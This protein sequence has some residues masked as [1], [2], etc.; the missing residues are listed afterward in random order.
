VFEFFTQY[1]SE[2][3]FTA[4]KG[5]YVKYKKQKGEYSIP[6]LWEKGIVDDWEIFWTV[7]SDFSPV[8]AN[9]AERFL[10]TLPNSVPS[11]RAFFVFKLQYTFL[12]NRL[13]LIKLDYLCFLFMNR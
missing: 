12:R 4:I 5:D 9:F 13:S 1:Y 11:E 10:N 8:L 2:S 6:S 7:A 3:D